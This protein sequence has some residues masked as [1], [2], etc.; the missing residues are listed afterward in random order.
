MLWNKYQY[1]HLVVMG[2]C[3]RYM[4]YF[5]QIHQIHVKS[6]ILKALISSPF[7]ILIELK[8]PS[9]SAALPMQ[10]RFYGHFRDL[11]SQI[12]GQNVIWAFSGYPSNIKKLNKITDFGKMWK[13][14]GIL[15]KDLLFKNVFDLKMDLSGD[16]KHETLNFIF[17]GQLESLI[18]KF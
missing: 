1:V 6:K 15:S 11:F 8:I 3:H 16:Q 5:S 2:R 12:W 4:G 13:L 17:W 10:F 18:T 9:I 14:P 7:H